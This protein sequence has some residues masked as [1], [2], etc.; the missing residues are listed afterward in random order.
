MHLLSWWRWRLCR[1]RVDRQHSTDSVDNNPHPQWQT[2]KT[3]PSPRD[4]DPYQICGSVIQ[5]ESISK[6]M[7]RLFS[8]F[9][10]AR[11]CAQYMKT[12]VISTQLPTHATMDE[13]LVLAILAFTWSR[14]CDVLALAIDVTLTVL[15]LLISRHKTQLTSINYTLGLFRDPI[16]LWSS[17]SS[18]IYAHTWTSIY[19]HITN[20]YVL[21]LTWSLQYPA[22]AM[23]RV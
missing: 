6:T 17:G 1:R 14:D 10:P 7:S 16:A 22:V 4:L 11:N 21:L 5:H 23:L 8:H 2:E 12:R 9:F 15:A 20:V 19:L 3:V 18:G 13:S